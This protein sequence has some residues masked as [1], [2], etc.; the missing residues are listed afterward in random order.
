MVYKIIYS[1]EVY[2]KIK[3]G[4]EVYCL[5]RKMGYVDKLNELQVSE[6]VSIMNNADECKNENRY[7]FWIEE[8]TGEEVA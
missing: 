1:F 5:D 6:F 3:E 2:G 4:K 8:N 7:E